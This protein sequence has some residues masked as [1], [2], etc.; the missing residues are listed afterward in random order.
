[1]QQRLETALDGLAGL[2]ACE[3]DDTP[4]VGGERGIAGAVSVEGSAGVLACGEGAVL[5]HLS[6]AA[7]WDLLASQ[8]SVG[9]VTAPLSRHGGSA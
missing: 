6:A 3:P 2:V 5:S 7:H 9:D 8:A 4:A 1:M